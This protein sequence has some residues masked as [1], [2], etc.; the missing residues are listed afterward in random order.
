MSSE[1]LPVWQQI[2]RYIDEGISVIPV[3]DKD[4][5]EGIAKTPYKKRWKEYQSEI[6]S[7]ELLFQLMDEEYNTTAVATI[8]GAVSGNLEIIDIDVK[9][10]PGIDALIFTDLKLLYPDIF[11]KLRIVK[12]PSGG[13]HLLYRCE[14][15]IPG[16]QKLAGRPSTEQELIE[17]PKSKTKNFIETRGE[18]GY[19]LAPPSLGYTF[20]QDV[21][22]AVLSGSDRESII[23]LMRSYSEIIKIEAAYKPTQQDSSY[24]ETNPFDDFNNRCNPSELMAS[25][26]WEECKSNSHFIWYTRPG[27]SKGVSLS[28][29]LQKRFFFN[30]TAST[31][32]EEYKGYTPAN[33]LA[34]LQ[35]NNDKKQLYKHLV[36]N[37]FGV[38]KPAVESTIVKRSA[39]NGT[40]LP[41]NLSNDAVATFEQITAQ[42]QEAHP[43]GTFWIDSQESGVSIDRKSLY[44][45]SE[46]LGFKLHDGS[47][48]RSDGKYIQ[49]VEDRFYFDTL[50]DYIH[51]DDADLYDDIFNAF[52][53]FIEK[54]GKFTITRLPILQDHFILADTVD[55]A[56][57]VY[58]NVILKI[59][60]ND[61]EYLESVPQLIW[62]HNVQDREFKLDESGKYVQ[63]LNLATDYADN[64]EYI[65]SIIGY[66]AHEYKDETAGY[67]IVLTEQCENPKEGGGAG[68][69]I[70]S[71]L[72]KHTTTYIGK[73]GSQVKYDEKFMQSW[74]GQKIYCLSDVPKNF[75]YGFLKEM[76]AGGGLQKKLFK[77]ESA[78]PSEK[79]PK[80]LIQT[81][82]SYEVSD[83]GLKRRIKPIEFTNYFTITGGV[84]V[85]FGVHFPNGWNV[86]DWAGYDTTIAL[87]IQVWLQGNRK[88]QNAV[89][90][91]SGW[92]KQF[93]Q[94]YGPAIYHFIKENFNEWVTAQ[95]ITNEYFKKELDH[96]YIENS[97]PNQYKPATA[98]INAGLK[99]WCQHH[100]IQFLQ[101]F[102][103]SMQG[104]KAR[105]KWFGKTA[106]TPF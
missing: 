21:P 2:E 78:I 62:K 35:F 64:R 82:F 96:F 28:F 54:H 51:E 14:V 47:L 72:F 87:S 11:V 99:D 6:I 75:N 106:E 27:K 57:K 8:G 58:R 67:I 70:F 5:E 1:L 100:G 52:E 92:M 32:L 71:E 83:G 53:A 37:G 38:I 16:N 102:L 49:Y 94:T 104:I 24:Y 89:L 56:Y 23:S 33:I 42:M 13:Y 90:S 44:E 50:R 3:R 97:T 12:S 91:N 46:G 86:Q 30:F 95:W 80:F 88:I 85:F 101:D 103:K 66:L 34:M 79:M 20:I 26:G 45:V 63:F 76:S 9:Y 41:A 39:V 84:D 65:Q 105:C 61:I 31:E 77:D 40:S 68:K 60:A 55:A 22:L 18:G 29:N 81:N 4:D 7:R 15:P 69:N 36:Q 48:I 98:K 59:T 25:L 10:K 74:N 19:V 93:E 43:Y 17:N 73:P